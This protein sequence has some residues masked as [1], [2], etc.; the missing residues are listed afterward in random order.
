MV[1][2]V[3]ITEACSGGKPEVREERAIGLGVSKVSENGK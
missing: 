1:R 2:C 3:N